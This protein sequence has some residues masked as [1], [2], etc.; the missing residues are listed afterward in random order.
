MVESGEGVRSWRLEEENTKRM[1]E[2]P[3]GAARRKMLR[4]LNIAVPLFLF[5]E[6]RERISCI[7]WF[8]FHL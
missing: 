8:L 4:Y 6:R 2:K 1:A 5:G 7:I 3:S